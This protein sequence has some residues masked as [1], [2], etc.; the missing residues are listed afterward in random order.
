MIDVFADKLFVLVTST[1]IIC[2]ISGL[3]YQKTKVPDI[4]WVLG[5]GIL[6]G[7]VLGYFD[8]DLFL[9]I[10]SIMSTLAL[11]FILFDAGINVDITTLMKT[12]AKSTMLA[13]CIFVTIV[14]SVGLLFNYLMPGSF[15]LL[16]GL[17]LGSMISGPST[18]AVFGILDG[19]ERLIPSIQSI[20]VKLMRE[21]LISDPARSCGG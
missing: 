20:R 17:L 14:V 13:I 16:Q 9:S 21:S 10:S 19:V 18:I 2:Y 7:P 5:F 1:L 15:M 12:M 3:F 8:K 4:I 11:S 6:L